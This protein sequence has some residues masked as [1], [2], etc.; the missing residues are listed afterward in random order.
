MLST[1]GALGSPTQ[2]EIVVPI[3]KTTQVHRNNTSFR[4]R[5]TYVSLRVPSAE[6]VS[7]AEAYGI[8]K[9]GS[10]NG[11]LATWFSMLYNAHSISVPKNI[12]RG[13]FGD[14]EGRFIAHLWK[15][16]IEELGITNFVGRSFLTP[17]DVK[18]IEHII[19]ETLLPKSEKYPPRKLVA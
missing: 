16:S 19:G 1:S 14:S 12:I 4:E 13:S 3:T 10:A 15:R 17:S 9:Y 11:L 8:L 7:L 2:Y 6:D 5:E 18:S